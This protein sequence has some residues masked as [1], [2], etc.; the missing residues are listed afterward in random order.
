M[1]RVLNVPREQRP[2]AP[3][4]TLVYYD[5]PQ[6]FWL[7]ETHG[8]RYLAICIE[9]LVE[10]PWPFLVVKMTPCACARLMA[11]TLPL[12]QAVLEGEACYL[13][14]DYGAETLELVGIVGQTPETWLPGNVPLMA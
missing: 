3:E 2:Y 5:G 11:G 7:T 14:A 8:H 6:L 9:G 1:T 10:A 13:L 12:R 4:T